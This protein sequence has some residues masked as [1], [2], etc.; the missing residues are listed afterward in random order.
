MRMLYCD[1]S[2]LDRREND[3]FVYC[4]VFSAFTIE[5]SDSHISAPW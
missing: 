2:N 1:E 4:T 5:L 3:F